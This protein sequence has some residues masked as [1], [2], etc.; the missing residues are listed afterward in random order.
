MLK[1]MNVPL[2][3]IFGIGT[4]ISVPMVSAETT[5]NQL[6]NQQIIAEPSRDTAIT[7]ISLSPNEAFKPLMAL[8]TNLLFDIAS[9]ANLEIEVP[10]NRRF[11][12]AAE[13]M[14][15]W[16]R[17]ESRN[18]TMQWHA[19]H[20]SLKHWLNHSGSDLAFSGWSVGAYGGAGRYDFQFFKI[21]GQQGDYWDIGIVGGYA[22]RLNRR[23][24]FEF[25]LAAG[26]MRRSYKSY[27]YTP[28]TQYGNIKVFKYPWETK[29]NTWIGPLNAKVS[30]VWW[31]F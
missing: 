1:L 14:L 26:Y 13:A 8:K 31:L 4:L 11:T 5:N 17:N 25:A 3:F 10:V 27:E 22:T 24:R 9:A 15:P 29:I 6:Q 30:L 18:Y 16:W 20:L 23:L 19:A 28:D 21:N 7:H 2:K 12:I